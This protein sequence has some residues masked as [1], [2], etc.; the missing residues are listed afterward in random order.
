M[1]FSILSHVDEEVFA[2]LNLKFL[3][4]EKDEELWADAVKSLSALFYELKCLQGEVSCFPR[5]SHLE[6]EC[7]SKMCKVVIWIWERE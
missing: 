7:H 1:L 3:L 6:R 2:Y 5:P 4:K